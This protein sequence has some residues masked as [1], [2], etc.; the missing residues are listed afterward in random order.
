MKL[1]NVQ[2]NEQNLK[3]RKIKVFCKG[4]S[5]IDFRFFCIKVGGKKQG[6]KVFKFLRRND[7]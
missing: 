4:R 3:E 6:I 7:F 5:V 2:D 1:Y